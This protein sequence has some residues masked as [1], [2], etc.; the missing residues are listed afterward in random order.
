MGESG[1]RGERR[2]RCSLKARLAEEPKATGERRLIC[3]SVV[4]CGTGEKGGADR[5]EAGGGDPPVK[6]RGDQQSRR[7]S[8]A[9][10]T[11]DWKG[12]PDG[13]WQGASDTQRYH[14]AWDASRVDRP[15]GRDE[16][17]SLG[18]EVR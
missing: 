4:E 14:W 7:G 12:Q 16:A 15:V 9:S 13:R 1:G 2:R 10:M 6:P 5:H 3:R 11:G 17:F 8:R 18:A